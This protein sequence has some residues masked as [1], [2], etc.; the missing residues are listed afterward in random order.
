MNTDFTSSIKEAENE[1]ARIG[2]EFDFDLSTPAQ[3][4][5]S[6]DF[7][8]SQ[9]PFLRSQQFESQS[10]GSPPLGS[11][12]QGTGGGGGF[13]TSQSRNES[14]SLFPNSKAV[15]SALRTLQDKI[16]KTEDDKTELLRHCEEL[17]E[18]LRQVTYNDI[19]I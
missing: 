3:Q 13:E 7:Q 1:L 12:F 10:R 17:E 19:H 4:L 8:S 16:R 9:M 5:E 14:T 11:S 18:Q 6:A 2:Q 15:M